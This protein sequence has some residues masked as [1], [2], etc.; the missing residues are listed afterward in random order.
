M[1]PEDQ[2]AI[3]VLRAGAAG[4]LTK[5]SAS[6]ELVNAVRK[7]LSGKK[8]GQCVLLPGRCKSNDRQSV[9]GSKI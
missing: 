6:E 2:Y 3:R 1:H 9:R 7:I 8:Y 5:G 4:Y